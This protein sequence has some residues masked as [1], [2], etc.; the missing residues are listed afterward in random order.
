M[1]VHVEAVVP[2]AR[3]VV[4]A[5][6]EV[7]RQHCGSALRSVLVHGSAVKG[8]VIRGCSDVDVALFVDP[9][10]LD[11]SAGETLQRSVAIHRDL[12]RIDPAPFRYLQGHLYRA[13]S[14]A[15]RFAP[16]TFTVVWGERR[17]PV[18]SPE[19]VLSAARQSLAALDVDT[20][21]RHYSSDLLD[22]GGGRLDHA[23]RYLCT[24][25]WPLLYQ[26]QCVRSGDGASTWAR[27]KHEIVE[28]LASE[29]E[30]AEP[31]RGWLDAVV[32]H[33]GTG[34]RTDTALAALE[35]GIAAATAIGGWACRTAAR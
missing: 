8:G 5:A 13:G 10:W 2:E 3:D 14:D 22:H 27:T 17:V 35:A 28:Q 11:A 30:L 7:Y 16:Q 12:A 6:V 21:S 23:V 4:T 19:D 24:D 25:I 29:P 33:Y 15:K 18:M 32:E 31:V 34:E 9:D 26:A 1:Q 20:L